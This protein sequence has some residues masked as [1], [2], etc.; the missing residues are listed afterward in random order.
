MRGLNRTAVLFTY[1]FAR[2]G[3]FGGFVSAVSLVPL[4]SVVSFRPFRFIN[5]GFSTFLRLLVYHM[6]GKTLYKGQLSR[7]CRR[8]NRFVVCH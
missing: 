1:N 8:V 3:R 7:S 2:F 6:Q 4:V 5:S